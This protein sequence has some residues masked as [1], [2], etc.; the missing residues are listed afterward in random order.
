MKAKP[1]WTKKTKKRMAD[2]SRTAHK[3]NLT[4]TT[5]ADESK[6]KPTHSFQNA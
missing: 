3:R 2:N 1:P 6:P 4:V 5:E